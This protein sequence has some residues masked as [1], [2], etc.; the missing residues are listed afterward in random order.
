MKDLIKQNF[1]S[2]FWEMCR[3]EIPLN[4]EYISMLVEFFPNTM[5]SKT[6][7]E[8][9]ISYVFSYECRS[10]SAF[11]NYKTFTDIIKAY[12]YKFEDLDKDLLNKIIQNC[13]FHNRIDVLLIISHYHPDFLD[14]LEENRQEID[15]HIASLRHENFG[16]S[17]FGYTADL[18]VLEWCSALE[19]LLSKRNIEKSIGITVEAQEKTKRKM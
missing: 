6:D 4:D 1:I 16:A 10:N 8:H 18:D 12:G 11:Y 19:A 2:H 15:S 7:S 14:A 17:I 5:Q 9:L 3:R 13:L